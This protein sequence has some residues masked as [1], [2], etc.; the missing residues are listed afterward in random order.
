MC[1]GLGGGHWHACH[2]IPFPSE[3]ATATAS[4]AAAVPHRAR[5]LVIWTGARLGTPAARLF[6]PDTSSVSSLNLKVVDGDSGRLRAAFPLDVGQVT[7]G[8]T[9]KLKFILI[10]RE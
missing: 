1:G 5:P 2:I 3:E 8:P 7:G 6:W 4:L 10:R 9:V